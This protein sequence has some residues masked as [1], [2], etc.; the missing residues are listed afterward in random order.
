MQRTRSTARALGGPLGL[1]AVVDEG[2]IEAGFGDWD[3]LTFGEVARKWP[4]ELARWQGSTTEEPP[5]G[6]ESLDAVVARVR[7]AR[8]RTAA[9]YAGRCVVV[10]THVTPVRVVVQEALDAG[11]ACL[12]RLAVAPCSVTI[13]RFWAD[14]GAEIR[15]VNATPA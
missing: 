5:G 12:W 14:G 15:T 1:D 9:A 13:A 8:Q 2:W 10:V 11:P 4:H 6:G 3:G 7:A